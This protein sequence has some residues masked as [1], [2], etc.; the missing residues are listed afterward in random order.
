LHV[1]SAR[2]PPPTRSVST[3]SSPSACARKNASSKLSRRAPGWTPARGP[4]THSDP[5]PD[6]DPPACGGS[7]D[8]PPPCG[9]PPLVAVSG[10]GLRQL[11]S[12]VARSAAAHAGADPP[13]A[14]RGRPAAEA[15][16][17]SGAATPSLRSAA[18]GVDAA[19]AGAALPP[20]AGECL[21]ADA[22]SDRGIPAAPLSNRGSVPI[23]SPSMGSAAAG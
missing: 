7:A 18:A 10:L 21:A 4:S 11:P 15:G 5:S 13:S 22:G 3:H 14:A 19:F 9:P 23:V 17:S 1:S 20:A 16:R 6:P 12:P 2:P 8:P